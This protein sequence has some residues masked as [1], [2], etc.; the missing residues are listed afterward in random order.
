MKRL[1]AIT[2]AVLVI[3]L[4]VCLWARWELNHVLDHASVLKDEVWAQSERGAEQA[5][6]ESLAALSAYWEE[7]GSVLGAFCERESLREVTTLLIEARVS[8]DH[9]DAE[10]VEESLSLI[11]EALAH[12]RFED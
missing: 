11:S 7:K 8:M 9:G 12:V 3:A 6:S 2:L 10:G 5:A 4:G 1:A